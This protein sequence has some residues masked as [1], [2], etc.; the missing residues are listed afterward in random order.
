VRSH[1][2]AVAAPAS[3]MPVVVPDDESFVGRGRVPDG[4][5]A[6]GWDGVQ[7]DMRI[8]SS[9]SHERRAL[10]KP[11]PTIQRSQSFFVARVHSF[12]TIT[13]AARVPV[14]VVLALLPDARSSVW[15]RRG[16]TGSSSSRECSTGPHYAARA[17]LGLEPVGGLW[18]STQAS[19]TWSGSGAMT[20][21]WRSVCRL[22]GPPPGAHM[23][24]QT[25]YAHDADMYKAWARAT[26][27]DAFDG[28]SNARRVRVA[29][30]AVSGHGRVGRVL[31]SRN[32]ANQRVG[33]SSS[34]SRYCRIRAHALR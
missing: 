30:C 19:P 17:R 10:R 21:R 13:M 8:S 20:A 9:T 31:W 26:I 23:C 7:G 1:G 12:E 27:D 24:S 32:A 33:P 2:L 25:S 5:Q 11:V 3:L 18:A 15:R 22:A 14:R 28:R 16:F 4:D 29:T 34:D 6:S